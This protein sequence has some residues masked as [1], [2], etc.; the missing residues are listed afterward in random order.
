MSFFSSPTHNRFFYKFFFAP[1]T[2]TQT[3]MSSATNQQ[4]QQ[5]YLHLFATNAV[6]DGASLFHSFVYGTDEEA[7][8]YSFAFAGEGGQFLL[9]KLPL[10][11]VIPPAEEFWMFFRNPNPGGKNKMMPSFAMGRR[12]DILDRFY[13]DIYEL[14]KIN[15]RLLSDESLRLNVLVVAD[16]RNQCDAKKKELM[17]LETF[18]QTQTAAFDKSYSGASKTNRPGPSLAYQTLL[19]DAHERAMEALKKHTCSNCGARVYSADDHL[20]DGAMGSYFNCRR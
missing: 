10:A 4:Q 2:Q 5:R 19:Q 16:T 3:T 7:K 1:A 18:L 17:A 20:M 12:A 6:K 13:P 11:T 8:I 14:E 15:V 9:S